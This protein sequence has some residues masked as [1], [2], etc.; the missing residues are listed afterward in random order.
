MMMTFFIG[1]A[2]YSTALVAQYLGAGHKERCAVVTAQAFIIA[3]FAYPII[4]ACR[5][6]AHHL[7][8]GQVQVF[9]LDFGSCFVAFAG[10]NLPW[11]PH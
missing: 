10:R 5:P 2:G 9:C 1:L 3:F 4:L 6:L 7:F 8:V 11:F